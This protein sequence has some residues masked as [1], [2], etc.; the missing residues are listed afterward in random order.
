MKARTEL[1]L[2]ISVATDHTNNQQLIEALQ[3]TRG[4]GEL[5]GVG[6]FEFKKNI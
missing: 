1:P 4:K 2:A 5:M 3:T 6:K